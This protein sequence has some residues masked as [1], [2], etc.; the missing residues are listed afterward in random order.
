MCTVPCGTAHVS[1]HVPCGTAHS[2][3]RLPSDAEGQ[4]RRRGKG[5]EDC[6]E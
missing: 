4:C 1:G 2:V 6:L 3:A 5:N